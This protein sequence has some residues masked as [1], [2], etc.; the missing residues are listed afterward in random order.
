MFGDMLSRVRERKPHIHCITNYVTANDCAN[1]VLASGG[2]PIMADSPEESAEITALCDGLLLNTGTLHQDKLSAMRKSGKTANQ[3][4]HPVV[5]DPVG[6]GASKF[7][8]DSVRIILQEIEISVIRANLSEIKALFCGERISHGVDAVS[9][10]SITEENLP[11]MI[12]LIRSVAE[13]QNSVIAVTGQIDIIA[14]KKQAFCIRNGCAMMKSVTGAGCQ[15]SALT[16]VFLTAN[17]ENHLKAAAAAVCAMGVCGEIALTHLK[18]YEG[19]AS[20]R[21]HMID[22][23]FRLDAETLNQKAKYQ[24]FAF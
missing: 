18:S 1:I 15:L 17:P 14:D 7:R 10:D 6:A 23:V 21:N 11:D 3:L 9:S 13:Q 8:T 19:N 12:K 16:A 5:L 24:I 20:F 2:S 4:H 22:A